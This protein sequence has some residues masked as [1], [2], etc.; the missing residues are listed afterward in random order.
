METV[1]WRKC[2][3]VVVKPWQWLDGTWCLPTARV[4]TFSWF[5][6]SLTTMLFCKGVHRQHKTEWQYF[7]RWRSLCSSFPWKIVFRALPSTTSPIMGFGSPTV[8]QENGSLKPKIRHIFLGITRPFCTSSNMISSS[9]SQVSC[10]KKNS[11]ISCEATWHCKQ[12]FFC[13]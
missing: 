5:R 13:Y 4:S 3:Y 11:W 2:I 8:V 10:G 1:F 7:V 12:E 6:T 9:D